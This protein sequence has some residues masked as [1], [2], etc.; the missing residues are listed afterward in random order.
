[1]LEEEAGAVQANTAAAAA[2]QEEGAHWQIR[3]V[4]LL[5]LLQALGL[6]GAAFYTSAQID[7]VAETAPLS[8]DMPQDQILAI[9]SS[10]AMDTLVVSG[11][12]LFGA[13]LAAAA[14]IGFFF[15]WRL[16]WLLAIFTQGMVLLVSLIFYFRWKPPVVY[17]VLLYSII[18]VLY[19]NSFGVQAVFHDRVRRRSGPG[20][21]P[22]PSHPPAHRLSSP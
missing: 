8:M 13:V 11:F 18:L 16:G 17:P 22:G 10:R 7:W 14:A 6:V 20:S 12:Y 1:M 2:L 21:R 5:L 19:L 9:L 3:A 15:L 4:G